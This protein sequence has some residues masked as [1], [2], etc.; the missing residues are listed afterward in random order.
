[1]SNARRLVEEQA[2][3]EGLWFHAETCAEAYVQAA[4]RKLHAAVE[5]ATSKS[6]V[7]SAIT[8]DI[9]LIRTN[10]DYPPIPIRSMDWRAWYDSAEPDD[11]GNMDTGEGATETDAIADLIG[12]HPRGRALSHPKGTET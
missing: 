2:K 9:P 4:L 1:M 3:D 12:N 6:D 10:H 7:A 11:D 5:G 8:F